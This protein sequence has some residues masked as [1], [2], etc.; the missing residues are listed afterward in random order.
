MK[1]IIRFRSQLVGG[2]AVLAVA[3]FSLVA[4]AKLSKTG[5]SSA[6][7]KAAGPAGLNIEGKTS[8]MTVADD[9]TTVTITVPLGNLKT[10]IELRDK[11]TKDYLEVDKYPNAKLE[12]PRASLKFDGEGDAKGKLT[13]HGQTKDATFHY[14]AKKSG[15]AYD[16]KGSTKVNMNDYGIKTPTYMG[17]G[18]K[19]DV[20]VFANFQAKDN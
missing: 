14:S 18:V 1:S 19:P 5:D 12:V 2:A 7:F 16:I 15:D 20:D 8:D 10:G 13:I 4:A 6:G 3:T 9:G 11:H 17:V